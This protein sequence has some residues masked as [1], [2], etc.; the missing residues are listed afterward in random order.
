MDKQLDISQLLSKKIELLVIGISTGGPQTLGALWKILP[1]TI[2]VPIVIIQHMPANFESAL[3]ENLINSNSTFHPIKATHRGLIQKGQIYFAPGGQQL[4]V[5]RD[6]ADTK[7][8]RFKVT[9][10]PPVN[11]CLPSIDYFLESAT[12]LCQDRIAITIMTGMGNDGSL[13]ALNVKNAGGI[14]I[15]QNPDSCVVRGM[16]QAT[17]DQVKN[18]DYIVS[19]QELSEIISIFK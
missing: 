8:L 18:V 12:E 10:D 13:G 15:V 17:I 11:D 16:P 7:Q 4:K 2:N 14:V 19:I 5:Y 9:D 3:M 1:Q 6:P